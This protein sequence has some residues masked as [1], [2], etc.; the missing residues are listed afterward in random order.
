MKTKKNQKS[1]K[2]LFVVKRFSGAGKWHERGPF[3][4]KKKALAEME[5][6]KKSEF[7]DERS[8]WSGRLVVVERTIT[9]RIIAPIVAVSDKAAPGGTP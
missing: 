3:T 5:F 7:F 2:V 1:R 9:D 4:T 8:F 6:C